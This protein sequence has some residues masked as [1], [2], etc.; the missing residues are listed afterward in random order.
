M[1]Q[2]QGRQEQEGTEE[3]RLWSMIKNQEK[4]VANILG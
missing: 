3:E 1:W 4:E 2:D